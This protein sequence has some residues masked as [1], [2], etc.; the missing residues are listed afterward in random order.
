MLCGGGSA[1]PDLLDAIK[2]Y[3]WSRKIPF[4]RKPIVHYI[5]P[6]DVTSVIDKTNELKNPWDVTPMAM[7]SLA[8]D[9][10]GEEKV[11]DGVLSKVVGGLR[12]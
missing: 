10:V 12:L 7:A 5:N 11:V 8:I 3:K 9:L 1:L 2:K 4:A 6:K